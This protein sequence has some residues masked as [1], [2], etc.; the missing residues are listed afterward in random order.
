MYVCGPTVYDVPH[1]GHGRFVL[2][3]DILRRYLEHQG[4]KVVHVSNITDIDD[5]ILTRAVRE[6]LQPSEIASKYE[7]VWWETLEMLN[8]LRPTSVPHATQYIDEMLG[9]IQEL[10]R[11]EMAYVS[12]DGVYFDIAKVSD[13]GLLAHQTLDSLRAGARIELN[14]NKRSPLDFVLWKITHNE[15]WTWNS[16]YG[17]GRPGWHT[18]C[19]VMA[20]DLLG[21]SFDIHG[22]GAD[23][24]FPHHENERAQAISL[25]HNFASIW[26]HNGFIVTGGEKMSKSLENYVTLPE[27]VGGSDPRSY[28]LLVLQA[29]YRSPLEV[30]GALILDA[31]RA[32][33]R[34]DSAI[35]RYRRFAN[36]VSYTPQPNNAMIEAFSKH[37]DNDLD[38]PSATAGIFAAISRMNGLFDVGE[39][40]Q[41][42]AIGCGIVELVSVLGLAGITDDLTIPSEVTELFQKRELAR[43]K[44]DFQTSDELRKELLLRGWVVEDA[45]SGGILK[46]LR[47]V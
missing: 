6:N 38:T 13:Y 29:H 35:E 3:F 26:V 11:R 24:A 41:G 33:M 14:E 47:E 42:L 12:V 28:R 30:N 18:E 2:V 7:A 5:K 16:P 32:L 10:V 21:E 39:V 8:V 46:P 40:D 15:R 45:K 36:Q 19:V 27:L 4:Y 37:M 31:A 1:I 23:L 34:I 9:L 22:G 25:G 20:Q 44:K 43:L 17:R